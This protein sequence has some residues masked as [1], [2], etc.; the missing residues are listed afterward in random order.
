MLNSLCI[1]N[2][3]IVEQLELDFKQG[4][5]ALTGETGAGKSILIDALMLALGE[6]ADTAVI[7]PKATQCDISACFSTA[8]N[9][10]ANAWLHQHDL[11]SRTNELIVR[12]VIVHEGRS[13]SYINGQPFPS[14]KVKELGE[15]LLDIHGQ[16][17]HWITLRNTMNCCRR[18]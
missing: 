18:Y 15:L 8:K 2:F 10:A 11:T 12:R 5:T 7:R 3:A 4:M 17:Q 14:Q 9:P 1:T 16:H 6:R 13:K